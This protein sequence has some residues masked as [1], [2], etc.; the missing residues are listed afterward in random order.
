MKCSYWRRI[1]WRA[2]WRALTDGQP[3]SSWRLPASG[4]LPIN[5]TLAVQALICA[6]FELDHKHVIH[7]L[8]GLS[9]TGRQQRLSLMALRL[10]LMSLT[11]LLRLLHWRKT[12]RQL[13]GVI[14]LWLRFCGQGLG[15]Y[16]R[17]SERE[18]SI[19][20]QI[21]EISDTER[22]TKGQT[23]LEVLYNA[24]LSGTLHED[25]GRGIYNR[26]LSGDGR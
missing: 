20:W 11:I 9:L 3:Q 13:R 10:F 17:A 8:N 24:G 4:L 25:A 6:G 23:L 5:K 12:C 19:E 22:A 7:A 21:A 2:R 16:C 18:F 26:P 1:C 15:R 14:S